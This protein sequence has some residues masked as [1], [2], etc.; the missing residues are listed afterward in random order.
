MM[1][2]RVEQKMKG[3]TVEVVRVDDRHVAPLAEFIRQVWDPT[4]TPEGMRRTRAAAAAANPAALGKEIPTFLF[5]ANGRAVGHVTTIPIRLRIGTAEH[6]AHWVN[7]FWVLPQHRNGPVGFLLLREAVRHLGCALVLV[8]QPAPRRLFEAFGFIDLGVLPN[9]LRI[10]KPAKILRK[11][12]LAAIGLAGSPRWLPPAVRIAQRLG[13]AAAAGIAAAGTARLWTA[14]AG[15][16]PCP[17]EV[18]RPQEVDVREYDDL[19]RRACAEIAATPTRDGS[20]IRWRY[21]SHDEG[22]YQFVTVRDGSALAGFA[23]VRRPRAEGDPRLKGIRVATLSEVIFPKDLPNAGLALLAASEETAREV[24]AD[25]LLCSTSHRSLSP[26]LRR[27]AFVGLPGN[28]HFLVRDPAGNLALP[29][30]LADWWL[31]RGDMDADET[32]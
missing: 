32:F 6:L 28:L 17:F 27:R 7:G 10:L 26:L 29:Q 11:L 1:R 25:A 9:F 21:G 15:R 13:I 3:T 8:V 19:W 22:R 20:Y 30:V 18:Q 24:E 4:A 16:A 23:A 5:L 2:D 31:T 14:A 12:D